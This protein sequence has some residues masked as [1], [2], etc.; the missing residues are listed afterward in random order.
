MQI[1]S[2]KLLPSRNSFFGGQLTTAVEPLQALSEPI[3]S[4]VVLHWKTGI[5][6]ALLCRSSWKFNINVFSLSH[7]IPPEHLSKIAL[8]HCQCNSISTRISSEALLIHCYYHLHPFKSPSIDSFFRNLHSL[9]RNNAWRGE[10]TDTK[11]KR[12]CN[13][14]EDS[15]TDRWQRPHHLHLLKTETIHWTSISDTNESVRLFD[16]GHWLT[17]KY[18]SHVK[19]HGIASLAH[20]VDDHCW[21]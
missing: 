21:I 14:T 5:V 15:C 19:W 17:V 1:L 10:S 6:I 18:Q 20:S 8:R 2:I 4:A 11:G 3:P 7:C 12:K 13:E 9:L 16:D